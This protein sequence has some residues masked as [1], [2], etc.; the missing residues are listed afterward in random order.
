MKDTFL[1]TN[2]K[3]S[4]SHCQAN[5]IAVSLG[6]IPG[7]FLL[8]LPQYSLFVICK[9][10]ST[11]CNGIQEEPVKAREVS[12]YLNTRQDGEHFQKD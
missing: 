11:A 9:L 1:E 8:A 3:S 2:H 6:G 12:I 5:R 10:N 7:V 4:E